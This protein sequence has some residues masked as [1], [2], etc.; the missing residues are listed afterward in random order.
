MSATRYVMKPQRTTA[1]LYL[2]TSTVGIFASA[3]ETH[4]G[5]VASYLLFVSALCLF[6]TTA[7]WCLWLAFLASATLSCFIVPGL[8]RDLI[9]S[10]MGYDALPVATAAVA[11]LALT[12]LS[13][14]VSARAIFKLRRPAQQIEIVTK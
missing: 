9:G 6:F 11:I 1:L 8:A 5:T 10:P 7:K 2:L 12:L 13:L 4:V 14:A 3:Y